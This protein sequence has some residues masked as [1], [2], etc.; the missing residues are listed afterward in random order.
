MRFVGFDASDSSYARERSE[1]KT[2]VARMT[3]PAAGR[4]AYTGNRMRRPETTTSTARA[5]DAASDA[6]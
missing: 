5:R 1:S 4:P 3:S 2:R 6:E